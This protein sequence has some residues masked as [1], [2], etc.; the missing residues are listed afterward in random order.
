M[1]QSL[2]IDDEFLSLPGAAEELGIEWSGFP[3]VDRREVVTPDG[4]VSSVRW[5]GAPVEAILLHGRAPAQSA[6]SW[7]GVALDWAAPVLAVDLP[8]HGFSAQRADRRYTPRLIAPAVATAVEALAP[9]PSLVV[10]VSFGGLTT[11]ALAALRPELV[12]AIALVDILPRFKA[13][14]ADSP[15][16]EAK[17]DPQPPAAPD[18]FGSREEI[19]DSLSD[20]SAF[21][22][23]ALVRSVAANTVQL[24]DGSWV[25]RFD[26]GVKV[27]PDELDISGLWDDLLGVRVPILLVRGGRSPVVS[28]EAVAELQ[29]RRPDVSVVSVADSGHEVH[30]ERP[31][32]LAA[33]LEDFR[34]TLAS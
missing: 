4:A 22:R 9:A 19:V 29:E 5:G 1:S 31:R 3:E 17:D 27:T 32:E 18:R 33:V 12:K 34:S 11:I 16:P 23:E 24:D 20:G 8:G 26:A 7:D 6:R 30:D 28:D 15:A 25:W 2:K 14:A 10:G 21:S 13:P